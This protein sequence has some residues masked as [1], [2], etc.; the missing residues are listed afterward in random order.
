[1]I[2]YVNL[3]TIFSLNLHFPADISLTIN[4][5]NTNINTRT[6]N[7]AAG[8]HLVMVSMDSGLWMLGEDMLVAVVVSFSSKLVFILSET[9]QG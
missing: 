1:M 2:F 5:K 6:M 7:T 9:S 4:K 8:I 3:V